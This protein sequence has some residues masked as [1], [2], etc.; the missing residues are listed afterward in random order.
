MKISKTIAVF[1]MMLLSF[2]CLTAQKT[3]T[4]KAEET[5]PLKI[6]KIIGLSKEP[7]TFRMVSQRGWTTNQIYQQ[8]LAITSDG[9][10]YI[11][12]D[13]EGQIEVIAKPC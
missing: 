8:G 4:V 6:E 10:I 2:S 7:G 9:S 3:K 5:N 12:D 1:L 13:G 11:G